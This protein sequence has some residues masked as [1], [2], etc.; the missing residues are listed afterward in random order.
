[1]LPLF[2]PAFAHAGG[3]VSVNG[4]TL[5]VTGTPERDGV[6]LNFRPTTDEFQV[7]PI[8]QNGAT[9]P[10]AAGPGCRAE[11][12]AAS[13]AAGLTR[14]IC[15]AAGVTKVSFAVGGGDD[16]F[17]SQ[18]DPDRFALTVD[19][20]DGDD[21]AFDQE[22][23]ASIELGAGDD[24]LE[25][26]GPKA[27]TVFGGAGKDDIYC[28]G[29]RSGTR[30]PGARIIDAGPDRDRVC[31]GAGDDRLDG[32]AGDDKMY[33]GDGDDVVDGDAGDDLLEG[34]DENDRITGGRGE[35]EIEGGAGKDDIRVFDR[36]VDDVACGSKR[37]KVTAD[38]DD[39]L[40]RC[41]T[42]RLR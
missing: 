5:V 10:S 26:R 32:G 16:R 30:A 14:Y 31:G 28:D 27:S 22:G 33:A 17:A 24:K 13:G 9:G 1:V 25:G 18:L 6:I 34:E 12:G 4:D 8:P 20:G 42:V 35:D 38:R 39:D 2:L 21:L 41:E 15:P 7:D 23:G 36:E 29:A 37:D 11:D 3:T 19:M 40:S